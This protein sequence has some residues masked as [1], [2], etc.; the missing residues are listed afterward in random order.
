M[1]QTFFC[2]L[3]THSHYYLYFVDGP[4]RTL[5]DSFLS[6]RDGSSSLG[7]KLHTSS[8]QSASMTLKN[9]KFS[10]ELDIQDF[11]PEDIDIKVQGGHIVLVGRREIKRGQRKSES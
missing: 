8:S 7:H 5:L 4:R 3:Y 6:L 1:L 11:D 10:I 9:G 2:F